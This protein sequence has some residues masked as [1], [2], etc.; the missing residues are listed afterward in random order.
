M[1]NCTESNS[2]PVQ[3]YFPQTNVRWD[4]K[5]CKTQQIKAFPETEIPPYFSYNGTIKIGYRLCEKWIW[6]TGGHNAGQPT[7]FTAYYISNQTNAGQQRY[8]AVSGVD[9]DPFVPVMVETIA[10]SGPVGK[11]SF[12]LVLNITAFLIGEVDEELLNLPEFC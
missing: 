9:A 3:P 8:P 10:N 11:T 1:Q 2:K 4:M 6:K 12:H 5:Q 7:S